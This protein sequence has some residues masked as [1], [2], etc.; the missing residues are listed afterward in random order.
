MGSRREIV[1]RSRLGSN[2]KRNQEDQESHAFHGRPIVM[3][4]TGRS[5]SGNVASA[6]KV[7]FETMQLSQAMKRA[8]S[9]INSDIDLFDSLPGEQ[10]REIA[11]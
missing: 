11:E 4:A 8:P 2:A 3:P 7:A 6:D 9:N 5:F 1:V 10:A